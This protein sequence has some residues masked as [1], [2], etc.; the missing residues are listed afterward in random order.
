M[1]TPLAIK[2][3][4]GVMIVLMGFHEFQGKDLKHRKDR[5]SKLIT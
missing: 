2:D 4:Q 5:Q 1:N 3:S